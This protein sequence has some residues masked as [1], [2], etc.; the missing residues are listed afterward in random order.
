MHALGTIAG[1]AASCPRFFDR[2]AAQSLLIAHRGYRSCYPENTLCA[3]EQCLGRSRMIELDVQLTAD[4]VAVVFHD[5]RLT[6]TSNAS[7]VAKELGL[8]SLNLCDWELSQLRFLDLGTWF[9]DTD[10]FASLRRGLVDRHALLSLMP[11]R[12]LTL[13]ELLVWA[14]AKTMPL[15]IEIKNMQHTR[16]NDLI[17]PEVIREIRSAAV[18]DE[19]VISSFNHEYLRTCRKLAPEIATAALRAGPPPPNL[20]T[21]LRELGVCAYHP[22]DTQVD[23]ALI[24]TLGATGLHVNVFTVNDPSRQQQLFRIGVTGIFT[25]FLTSEL[26][27]S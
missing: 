10:P 24:K 20:I 12:I 26:P 17:V 11:Q 2:F 22:E 18:T 19:V 27:V 23:E 6:R 8:S 3:F 15:N 5:R 9:I 14:G 7:L 4:G 25:D 13:R 16:M 1:N 21:Y